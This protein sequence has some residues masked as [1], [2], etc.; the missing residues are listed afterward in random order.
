FGDADAMYRLGYLYQR[1]KGVDKDPIIAKK[2][3][4]AAV[5][6]T[7]EFN[8][9]VDPAVTGEISPLPQG[10]NQ[11]PPTFSVVD[12]VQLSCGIADAAM[13]LATVTFRQ[14]AAEG[15]R[16]VDDGVLTLFTAAALLSSVPAMFKLGVIYYDKWLGPRKNGKGTLAPARPED[17]SNLWLAHLWWR[18]AS[19][20]GGDPIAMFNLGALHERGHLPLGYEAADGTVSSGKSRKP[21]LVGAAA[22]YALC[23]EQ[24][25]DMAA[26][27]EELSS[28]I[29]N[30]TFNLGVFKEKGWGGLPA[31]LEEAAMLYKDA[32]ER[33]HKR[34]QFN[35]GVCLK[36]GRGCKR[37]LE[38][39]ARWFKKAAEQLRYG[40][41]VE[42]NMKEAARWYARASDQNHAKAQFN[43]GQCYDEGDGVEPNPGEAARFF[44]MAADAGN[45]AGQFYLGMAM[46]RG[47][48]VPRDIQKAAAMYKLA[49]DQ[50]DPDAAA[51]LAH[52]YI[53]GEG[54]AANLSLALKYLRESAERGGDPD[55]Q[56]TLGSL[57]LK[58]AE[59]G[60]SPSPADDEREGFHWLKR[61]A[62]QGHTASIALVVECYSKGRGVERD[63]AKAAKWLAAAKA[64]IED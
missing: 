14:R 42:K 17:E 21:N 64:K 52:C 13:S 50:G 56:H 18:R 35:Y 4:Q 5:S 45:A 46:E 59:G 28:A 63:P 8:F 38:D 3:Y 23:V 43:L 6:R 19:L 20:I 48:G 12:R 41:G 11:L 27:G 15:S 16:D 58:S 2:W 49:A 29:V 55:T 61:A 1:G 40:E 25:R 31:A 37:S 47:R 54:V 10:V 26:T 62:K 9:S 57:L 33:G 60:L 39:A 36:R 22:W 34:A 7:P 24:S 51:A 53:T 44:Q 32:A 30:A